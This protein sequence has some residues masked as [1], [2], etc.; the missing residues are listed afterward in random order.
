VRIGVMQILVVFRKSDRK[1]IATF[2]LNTIITDMN[3][4]L[5]P[6]VSYLITSKRNIFYTAP[7]GEVFIREEI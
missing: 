1:V 4:L 2:E 6:E 5:I 3:V 7:N